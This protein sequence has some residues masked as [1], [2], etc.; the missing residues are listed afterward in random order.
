[1]ASAHSS[2]A[3]KLTGFQ[4]NNLGYQYISQTLESLNIEPGIH[5]ISYIERMDYKATQDKLRKK[6]H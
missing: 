1:M 6:Q 5:C 2:K 4:K 3:I